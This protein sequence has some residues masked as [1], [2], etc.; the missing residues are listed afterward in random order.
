MEAGEGVCCSASQP[1]CP[2]PLL[3]HICSSLFNIL[4]TLFVQPSSTEASLCAWCLETGMKD[5]WSL[6]PE[7]Q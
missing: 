2:L 1:E 3:F 7:T 5:T 6:M 4:C